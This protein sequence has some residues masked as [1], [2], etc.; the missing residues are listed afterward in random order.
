MQSEQVIL[1]GGQAIARQNQAPWLDEN[2][3]SNLVPEPT[4]ETGITVVCS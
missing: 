3:A 2:L 4:S 1:Q